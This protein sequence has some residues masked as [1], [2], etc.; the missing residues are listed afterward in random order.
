MYLHVFCLQARKAQVPIASAS[1]AM[2][3][4]ACQMIEAAK[5]LAVSPRDPPTYQLYSAHSKAV[6]DAIKKLLAAI[7]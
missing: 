5:Q 2:I 7:K 6:S 1:L 4:G 3:D